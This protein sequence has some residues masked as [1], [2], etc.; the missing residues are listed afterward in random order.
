M[1]PEA[2]PISTTT[3]GKEINE[4]GIDVKLDKKKIG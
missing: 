2:I 3:Q 1:G 4:G